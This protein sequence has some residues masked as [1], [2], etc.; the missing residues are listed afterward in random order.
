MKQFMQ[1]I[2]QWLRRRLRCLRLKQC[3]RAHAIARFLMS[4]GESNDSAYKLGARVRGGGVCTDTSQ[5][6]RAMS[7]SLVQGY[8]PNRPGSGLSCCAKCL[9]IG[10]ARC[11]AGT[12]GG[13]RG[14]EAQASPYLDW[15]RFLSASEVLRCPASSSVAWNK[16]ARRDC[17]RSSE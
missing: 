10:T 6:H 12:P 13:V 3:K 8:R 15:G 17:L 5:S 2:G 1:D 4:Q 11:R 16:K 14:E 9:L 7:L